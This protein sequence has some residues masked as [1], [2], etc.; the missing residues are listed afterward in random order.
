MVP[1]VGSV[2]SVVVY[3]D[4]TGQIWIAHHT[5]KTRNYKTDW[6]AQ[7]VAEAIEGGKTMEAKAK[8]QYESGKKTGK[9]HAS[10][11]HNKLPWWKRVKKKT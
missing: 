7:K 6:D 9:I 5:D 11:E 1:F 4:D 3:T 8:E 2:Y 10:Y